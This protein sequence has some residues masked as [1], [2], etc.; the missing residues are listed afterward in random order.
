[1]PGDSLKEG[2]M[3]VGTPLR[4]QIINVRLSTAE[5]SRLI[6]LAKKVD[7]KPGQLCRVLIFERLGG[8]EPRGDARDGA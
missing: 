2:S 5:K 8:D 4:D 7:R 3:L 1:V 6:E